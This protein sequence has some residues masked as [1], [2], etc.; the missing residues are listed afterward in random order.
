MLSFTYRKKRI[1]G[2]D[3]LRAA[4]I[5]F[6]VY[7]HGYDCLSGSHFNRK[8]Y[9][10]PV[11]LDGPTVFFVLSGF[12]VGGIIIKL[13]EKN[14][15]NNTSNLFHFWKRRWLRT[16][17]NYYLILLL[18]TLYWIFFVHMQYPF[19]F[20][21]K[22]V[23]F[24]QN[25][26]SFKHMFFLESWSLAIEEWFYFLF[27]ILFLLSFL[28]TKKKRLSIIITTC[29]FVFIPFSLRIIYYFNG[30]GLDDA[31]AFY[32]ATVLLRLDS[33]GYGVVG[34]YI[35]Y[36]HKEAWL[37]HK[38]TLLIFGIS[39]M[40]FV[41]ILL[42]FKEP[43]LFYSAVLRHSLLPAFVFLCL[44]FLSVYQPVNRNILHRII[45]YVSIV[46]YSMYLVNLT[47]LLGVVLPLLENKL[48]LLSHDNYLL[49]YAFYWVLT[50]AG[51][52]IL[53]LFVENPAMRWRDR[54][55]QR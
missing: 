7:A 6:V 8:L 42:L 24:M 14:N 31:K 44:P 23:F 4:A 38:N 19:W 53:Y 50:I 5:L 20:Y 26:A 16:L 1:F 3:I 49:I 48:H 12:L 33:I 39:F 27:P 36:Y 51:S 37:K 32:R 17:P 10:L 29:L 45:T 47:P 21:F 34:A 28:S 30:I 18:L 52:Y 22:Y 43:P 46:A 13:S 35:G 15:L 25:F 11:I 54:I 40:L 2:L 55:F 9:I 41:K